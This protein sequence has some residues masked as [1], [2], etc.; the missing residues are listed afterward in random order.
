MIHQLGKVKQRMKLDEYLESG[1]M[2]DKTT[3]I[4]RFVQNDISRNNYSWFTRII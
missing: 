1:K 4:L 2:N 3:Q